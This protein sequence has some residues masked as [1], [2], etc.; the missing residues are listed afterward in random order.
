MERAEGQEKIALNRSHIVAVVIIAIGF[1]FAGSEIFSMLPV[2]TRTALAQAARIFDVHDSWREPVEVAGFIFFAQ[3]KFLDQFY[4]A[5]NQ[6]LMAGSDL[7]NN[8]HLAV[9][10]SLSYSDSAYNDY[11]SQLKQQQQGYSAAIGEGMLTLSN[12]V[13]SAEFFNA[14]SVAD[15]EIFPKQLIGSLST[16]KQFIDQ[17]HRGIVLGLSQIIFGKIDKTKDSIE[18]S[19]QL[20]P[21]INNSSLTPFKNLFSKINENLRMPVS[22]TPQVAGES[23]VNPDIAK[24]NDH[25]AN[26]IM[27]VVTSDSKSS[28]DAINFII[29]IDNIT[30]KGSITGE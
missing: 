19:E 10:H 13:P 21:A 14:S 29:D 20:A 28:N 9:N 16:F 15:K 5:F 22:T 6:E 27:P 4:D 24:E 11:V 2:N 25:N 26:Q 12:N 17:I 3:E 18:Q 7:I 1:V 30:I 23:T 8:V